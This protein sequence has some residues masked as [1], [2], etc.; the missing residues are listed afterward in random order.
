M[1]F[2]TYRPTVAAT[3][4]HGYTFEYDGVTGW[5]TRHADAYAGGFIWIALAEDGHRAECR[6]RRQAVHNAV[7]SAFKGGDA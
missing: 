3:P 7:R 4:V 5:V 1:K 6:S 2:E